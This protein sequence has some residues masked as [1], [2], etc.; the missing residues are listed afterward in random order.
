MNT[1][2]LSDE[3]VSAY[4]RDLVARLAGLGADMPKTWCPIGPSGGGLAQAA[5]RAAPHLASA[6]Q[7][8]PI[9]FNRATEQITFPVDPDPGPLL[10]G[11]RVL[12]IDG[13]IHSGNTFMKAYRAVEA[14]KPADISSYA[15]VVRSGASVLPSFFGLAIGDHDRALFLKKAFPN[16][17][18]P[19]FGCVRKLC[20]GDQGRPMISCGEGFIDRFS[21]SDLLYEV[22]VDHRR[23]TYVYE[24][25]GCIQGLVSL[26]LV[27]G[28]DILIDTLGVDKAFQRQGIAGHLVRWA[29]TCGRNAHCAVTRLWGLEQRRFWYEKQGYET[30]GDQMV[31]DGAGF[32]LMSKKLLYNLPDDDVLTMGS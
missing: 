32:Y 7:N 31:L 8:I 14:L 12:L 24:R 25:G 6:I 29:E 30:S 20:D 19:A 10:R 3:E 17:R 9:A 4:L 22:R 23:K 15:L 5:M 28:D 18:L 16:N 21:W 11:K 2:F 27:P 13:S 26:R 1:V